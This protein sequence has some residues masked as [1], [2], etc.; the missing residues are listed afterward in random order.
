MGMGWF[1]LLLLICPLMMIFMM[2]GMHGPHD[3]HHKNEVSKADLDL[4][5]RENDL[6]SK[7]LSELKSKIK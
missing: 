4:L 3:N 1:L 2:K 6:L 5:K 7:E